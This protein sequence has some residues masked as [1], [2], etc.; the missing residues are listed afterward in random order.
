ML[1]KQT[2]DTIKSRLKIKAQGVETDLLLTYHNRRPDEFKAFFE[3]QENLKV[4]EAVN[5]QDAKAILAF[6]NASVVLYLVKSFDDGTDAE[7][8]LNSE[9]LVALE[10]FWPDALMCIIQGYHKARGAILEKN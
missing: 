4:P 1:T 7:F 3:N 8:P 9:G 5:K 10:D 6:V 2:P